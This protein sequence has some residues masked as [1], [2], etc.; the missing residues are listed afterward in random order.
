MAVRSPLL[1]VMHRAAEKAAKGLVRDFGELEQLQVSVKGVADFV[2]QADL[3]AEKIIRAEL[4]KARPGFGFLL[5]EGGEVEGDGQHRWIVDPLDGTTNF[6]HGIPH[7]AIS[8]ALEK[9]GEIVAG[10]I[11]NPVTDEMFTAEKGGGAFFSG[12]RMRVS[13]RRKMDEAVIAT[14]IPHKGRGDHDAYQPQIKRIM[15]QTA[16]VRRFGSAA[17][18]LAWVAAGRYD[19]FWEWGLSPWDSA[20]G[21]L[22]VKEAGGYVSGLE[23]KDPV[24]S[25]DLVASNEPLHFALMKLIKGGG[26]TLKLGSAQE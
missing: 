14:G 2:S 7:F 9:D 5:E 4:S 21:V 25:G 23:G 3:R 20:A 11:Y 12:R 22:M 13:A 1:N 17:L 18:D 6:L 19:G 10:L 16:G 24:F 8:I 26:N 15:A